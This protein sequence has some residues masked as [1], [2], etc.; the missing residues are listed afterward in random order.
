[1]AGAEVLFSILD[2]LTIVA[3][4]AIKELLVMPVPLRF[5]G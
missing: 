4:L 5:V 1:M 3:L 2:R